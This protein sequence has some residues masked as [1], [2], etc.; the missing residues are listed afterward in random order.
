MYDV[1]GLPSTRMSTR[2]WASRGPTSTGTPCK[3]LGTRDSG[4]GN[5]DPRIP[6]P[7]P[8]SISSQAL[9]MLS[10][11]HHIALR[12]VE[13]HLPAA[14]HRG[15]RH[16]QRDGVT[17]A[18]LDARVRLFAAAHALHPVPDGG[19]GGRIGTWLWRGLRCRD[20]RQ[21]DRA[22]HVSLH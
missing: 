22:H 14:V 15:D 9:R 1:N 2:R 10:T 5:S 11:H 16:A 8:P 18:R 13:H 20:L 17:V 19:G 7:K 4:L 12:V 21:I 6:S 3:G